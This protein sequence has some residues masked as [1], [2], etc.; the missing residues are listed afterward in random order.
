MNTITQVDIDGKKDVISEEQQS[1]LIS[2]LEQREEVEKAISIEP[3]ILPSSEIVIPITIDVD[4]KPVE[5]L[6]ETKVVCQLIFF[7]YFHFTI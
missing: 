7:K 6:V 1:P 2:T 3:T 5:Q 4:S